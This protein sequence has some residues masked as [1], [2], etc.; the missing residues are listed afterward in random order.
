VVIACYCLYQRRKN[1]GSVSLTT[2]RDNSS[3]K[4]A[5]THFQV[6]GD[7]TDGEENASGTA[8]VKPAENAPLLTKDTSQGVENG[9]KTGL[10]TENLTFTGAPAGEKPQTEGTG[11]GKEQPK[12]EEKPEQSEQQPKEQAEDTTDGKQEPDGVEMKEMSGSDSKKEVE[13]EDAKVPSED[14]AEDPDA[15][16]TLI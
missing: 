11:D 14:K 16:E 10:S 2:G 7:F 15:K 5:E 1:S 9:K 13:A 4:W 6:P 12:E 3:D 8:N